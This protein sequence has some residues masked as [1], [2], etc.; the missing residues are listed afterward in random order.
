MCLCKVSLTCSASRNRILRDVL[1]TQQAPRTVSCGL[2]AA[3]Q[4]FL[5]LILTHVTCEDNCERGEY[6][7]GASWPYAGIALVTLVL[8]LWTKVHPLGILVCGATAGAVLS[9]L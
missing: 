2:G 7:A 5:L 3:R 1:E 9:A 6:S 4:I 8:A